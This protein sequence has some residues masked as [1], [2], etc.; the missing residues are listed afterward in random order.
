[1]L[2]RWEVAAPWWACFRDHNGC[3][4]VDDGGCSV[5]VV[6]V[7]VRRRLHHYWQWAWLPP[8]SCFLHQPMRGA[9]VGYLSKEVRN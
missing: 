4:S 3:S 6:V 7:V 8:S 9:C 5:A 2:M 1:M